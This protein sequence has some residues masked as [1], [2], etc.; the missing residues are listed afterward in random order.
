[1]WDLL[2]KTQISLR[3]GT[4]IYWFVFFLDPNTF[5]Q[6]PNAFNTIL[7]T[8]LIGRGLA[9]RMLA[10]QCDD[11]SQSVSDCLRGSQDAERQLADSIRNARTTLSL[12]QQNTNNT[13]RFNTDGFIDMGIYTYLLI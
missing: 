3:F 11:S 2:K 8:S 13:Y 9:N 6:S 4:N 12:G 10:S 5:V 1:M 7:A